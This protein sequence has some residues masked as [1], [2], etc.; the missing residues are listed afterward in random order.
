MQLFPSGHCFE[1]DR[2]GRERREG[3]VTA[4]VLLVLCFPLRS[5]NSPLTKARQ[6]TVKG[7]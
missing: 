5:R 3:R 6:K 4:E 1:E 7:L 2:G